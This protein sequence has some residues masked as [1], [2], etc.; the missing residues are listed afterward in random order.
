MFELNGGVRYENARS[1]F[2]AEPK[3]ELA[4]A[5]SPYV[6]PPGDWV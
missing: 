3:P 5:D 1:I 6:V 2:R 4:L